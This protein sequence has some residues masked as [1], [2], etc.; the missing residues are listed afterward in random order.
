[1]TFPFRS[2]FE[3]I[4]GNFDR[5]S[6]IGLFAVV[7]LMVVSQPFA[8]TCFDGLR[9]IPFRSSNILQNAFSRRLLWCTSFSAL[10]LLVFVVF[11]MK[12]GGALPASLLPDDLMR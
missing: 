6:D 2:I 9:L 4:G 7:V 11:A 8:V 5:R 12:K 10:A 1:M 3:V